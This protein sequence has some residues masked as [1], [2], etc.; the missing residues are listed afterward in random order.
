MDNYR[1]Q[2]LFFELIRVSV[3]SGTCLS[4]IPSN[5]EWQMLFDMAK[6]QAIRGVCFYGIKC[7]PKEQLINMPSHIYDL[8]LGSTARI[9][10]R[11]EVA[12]ERCL[13]LQ[14]RLS[15]ADF[16]GCIL[17]GQGIAEIYTN[18]LFN[19]RNSGD[20]DIW[21]K[22]G[23]N[24][25]KDLAKELNQNLKVTE[26]HACLKF[27]K[28]AIVEVHF[29]PTMLRNPFANRFLQRWIKKQEK[30]QFN[31]INKQGL[32]VPT[33]E[34]NLVYLIIHTFRHVFGEGVVLRQV[35]D[36]YMVLC[37][38][39]ID[40]RLKTETM[41]CLHSLHIDKFAGGLMW[42]MKDIFGLTEDKM[43]CIPN[44][45]HGELILDELMSINTNADLDK[46]L[47]ALHNSSKL[48][49]FAIVNFKAFRLFKYYPHEAFFTPLTRIWT[50]MWRMYKGWI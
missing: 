16:V 32:C 6:Q 17:K 15:D 35:M 33:L 22:G 48:K 43:I 34:F 36:Y 50:W 45:M 1:I 40:I 10:K 21:V 18:E 12:N 24:A 30:T 44:K 25:T 41:N 2:S 14:K 38:K 31:N 47:S 46:N 4:Y 29:I 8:W 26:Q 19:L 23:L 42:V 5:K 20:I 37:S 9:Q 7:L 39:P 28:D 3:G 27:F 11:N 13:Q 49:R